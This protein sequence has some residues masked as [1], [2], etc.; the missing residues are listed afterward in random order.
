MHT[1]RRRIEPPEFIG[2]LAEGGLED[3]VHLPEM[4]ILQAQ[5][6]LQPN[7]GKHE[8]VGDVAI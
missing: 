4:G 3:R 2:K 8:K 6:A 5:Y 1:R 7:W